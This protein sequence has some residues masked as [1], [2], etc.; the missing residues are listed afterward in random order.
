MFR[1][2]GAIIQGAYLSKRHFHIVAF[3]SQYDGFLKLRVAVNLLKASYGRDLT[4]PILIKDYS[5]WGVFANYSQSKMEAMVSMAASAACT[6]K[7]SSRQ[8]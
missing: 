3:F 8:P 4:L 1:L 2:E 7:S 6:P 5:T